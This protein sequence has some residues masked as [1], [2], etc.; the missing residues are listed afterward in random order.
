M[1]IHTTYD[2]INKAEW[3]TLIANSSTATWFQTQA[4]YDFFASQPDLFTPF[5]FA[6]SNPHLCALC[7]G[8][9]TKEASSFKHFFTRRAIIIGGPVLAD[10]ATQDEVSSLMIAVRNSLRSKAIYIETRN[11]NSF[12][13]WVGVFEE[14]GFAYQKHLNFHVNTESKEIIDSNLSK[15]RKRD[16]RTSFREGVTII[17]S[18]SQ[19]QLKD[20]YA[21]LSRLYKTKV[22]T[23]L[24]PFSF[25]LQL[26]RHPDGRVLLVQY[27]GRI[28]GGLAGVVLP[29][30][31]MYEWFVAAEDGSYKNTFP[32]SVATYAGLLH[33][34]ENGIPRFDMMG[35]GTPDANYGVRDFKSRFGGE[36][37]EHGRFI[38][39]S[40][41]FLYKL[42]EVGVK[43][44][45]HL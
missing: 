40:H 27:N 21:I 43:I 2:S 34:A 1:T 15:N 10:N 22:K 26:S 30:R 23:P 24:F 29:N 42:G 14:A 19:Q 25:F 12:A 37:V 3:G 17:T 6:V 45:K 39:I 36:L 18:P 28:I 44:L 13:N 9:I 33:A 31:C 11:F 4:A 41:P 20:F 5:V 16:I 38:F 32:S 35:A 8:Y 7:V